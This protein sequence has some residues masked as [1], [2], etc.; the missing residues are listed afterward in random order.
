MFYTYETVNRP[1]HTFELNQSMKDPTF[2]HHP[3]TGAPIRRVI[4]GGSGFKKTC[5]TP[6]QKFHPD[7]FKHSKFNRKDPDNLTRR[8]LIN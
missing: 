3:E 7:D 1:H 6:K 5:F 8:E 2:T 4:T